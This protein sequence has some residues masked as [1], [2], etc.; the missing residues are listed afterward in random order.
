MTQL[1][2]VCHHCDEPIDDPDDAVYAGHEMGNSG[3]G[4]DIWAHRA[5]VDLLVPDPDAL[6]ILARVL[7]ER[8]LGRI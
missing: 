2:R 3:P 6:R 5:H 7:V 1:R 4:W 8:A